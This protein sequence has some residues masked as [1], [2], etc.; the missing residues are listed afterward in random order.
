[1]LYHSPLSRLVFFH[2]TLL[3]TVFWLTEIAL[4]IKKPRSLIKL[5]PLPQI[6]KDTQ[7]AEI[8]ALQPFPNAG[9]KALT[10]QN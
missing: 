1:M 9:Y 6:L 5:D 7:Y 4:S 10:N 2:F 3:L 8:K